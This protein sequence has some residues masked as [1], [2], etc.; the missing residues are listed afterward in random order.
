VK[1]RTDTRLYY[2]P[3]DPTYDLTV[4]QVWF[5]DEQCAVRALFTPWCKSSRKR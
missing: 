5:K 3:N 4:A 2:T 1:G